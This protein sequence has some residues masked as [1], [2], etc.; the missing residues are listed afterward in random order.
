MRGEGWEER[1]RGR[2]ERE[3]KEVKG[4]LRLQRVRRWGKGGRSLTPRGEEEFMVGG[5]ARC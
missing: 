4:V 5:G 3:G 2:E 1:K